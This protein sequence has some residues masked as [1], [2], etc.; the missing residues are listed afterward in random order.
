MD[1]ENLM[2]GNNVM[3]YL[4]TGFSTFDAIPLFSVEK[5]HGCNTVVW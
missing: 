3:A 1:C 4:P 5:Y 2:E